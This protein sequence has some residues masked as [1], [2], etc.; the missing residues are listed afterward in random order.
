DWS[1]PLGIRAGLLRSHRS[2][3]ALDLGRGVTP[4]QSQRTRYGWALKIEPGEEVVAT[5]QSFAATHGIRAGALSGIGAVGETELG[6]FV[7]GSATYVRR[8]FA[9]DHELGALT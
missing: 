9:G 6:F 2:T 3:R 7:P 8:T 5:I 4:M 1:E